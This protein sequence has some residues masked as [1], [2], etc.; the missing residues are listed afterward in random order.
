[1]LKEHLHSFSLALK[2]G[3][4]IAMGTDAAFAVGVNAREL[5]YLVQAGMT[6]MQAIVASTGRAAECIRMKHIVGTLEA[7]KEA[8]LL[9]IAGNP[10][11]DIT[12]LARKECLSLVMQAGIP[13][14]GPMV[15]QFPWKPPEYK[16]EKW[17]WS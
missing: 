3:V 15:Y 14:A 6:P 8:D 12:T 17:L 7:G 16:D 9:I 5:E 2:A 13:I 4:P 10:L 11:Q 1:M